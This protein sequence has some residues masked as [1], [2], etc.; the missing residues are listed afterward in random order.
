[1]IV[2]HD[3]Q[4]RDGDQR[5]ESPLSEVAECHEDGS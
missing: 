5:D 2:E 3:E 4:D 1:M